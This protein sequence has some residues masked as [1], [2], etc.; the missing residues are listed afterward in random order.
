MIYT[1][2]LARSCVD[3]LPTTDQ[4]RL[5]IVALSDYSSTGV[6]FGFLTG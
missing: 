5:K 4:R 3:G 6:F 2:Y 1:E